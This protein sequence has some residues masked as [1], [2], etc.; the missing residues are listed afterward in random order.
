LIVIVKTNGKVRNFFQARENLY[1]KPFSFSIYTQ[2]EG[3]SPKVNGSS[4]SLPQLKTNSY[5]MALNEEKQHFLLYPQN[6][7]INERHC[8]IT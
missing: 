3:G 7:S 4:L 1:N 5:V 6:S 2:Y 8:W